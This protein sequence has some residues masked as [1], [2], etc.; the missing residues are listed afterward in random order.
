M[1]Q[2]TKRKKKK[3]NSTSIHAMF[4][5]ISQTKMIYLLL[6]I[7][8]F[9]YFYCKDSLKKIFRTNKEESINQ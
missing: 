7:C 8:S 1:K 2:D 3:R 6:F 5:Q 4:E 9:I